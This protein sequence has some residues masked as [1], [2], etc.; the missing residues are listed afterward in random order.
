MGVP[1]VE[2]SEDI[3]LPASFW[4]SRYW[5]QDQIT[6]LLAIAAAEGNPTFFITMTC[7]MHWPKIQSQLQLGQD[8]MD[9]PISA[10]KDVCRMCMYQAC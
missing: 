1:D 4:G 9:I 7:N 10:E 6:D 8:Y 5:A 3:Y 2:A